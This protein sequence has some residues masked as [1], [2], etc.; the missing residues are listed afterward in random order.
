MGYMFE[1][2]AFCGSYGFTSEK[3][4]STETS[5]KYQAITGVKGLLESSANEAQT[6]KYRDFPKYS[7]RIILDLS[8]IEC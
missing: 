2:S 4:Q 6:G 1:R 8:I 5:A 7:G 3:S